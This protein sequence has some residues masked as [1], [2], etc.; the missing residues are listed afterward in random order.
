MEQ[1]QEHR[2]RRQAEQ[3]GQGVEQGPQG[4]HLVRIARADLLAHQDGG[5]ARNGEHADGAQ[6]GDV[7]RDGVGGQ[8]F[9]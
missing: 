3:K 2:A 7:A 9:L 6:V 1:A 4:V 5:G 8:D